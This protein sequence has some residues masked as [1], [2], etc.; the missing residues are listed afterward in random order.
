M[1]ITTDYV[2][3]FHVPVIHHHAEVV[4]RCAFR[5]GDDQIF[6]LLIG[7]G[8]GALDE[9]SPGSGTHLG[10]FKTPHRIPV[11]GDGWQ[12]FAR[13]GTPGAVITWLEPLG[14]GT[15]AH[16]LYLLRAAVALIGSARCQLLLNALP[17]AITTLAFKTW[18]L[19]LVQPKPLL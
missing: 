3:D 18:T 8:D 16:G 10:A 11:C 13:L 5:A 9:V 2:G 15:L 12:G 1:V 14:S 17:V 4:G 6:Q 7:D 19:F